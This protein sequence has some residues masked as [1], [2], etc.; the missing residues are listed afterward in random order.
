MEKYWAGKALAKARRAKKQSDFDESEFAPFIVAHTKKPETHVFCKITEKTIDRDTDAVSHDDE[1]KKFV[2]LLTH[3]ITSLHC[4]QVRRHI[5]GRRY[6]YLLKQLEEKRV[7][8][9]KKAEKRA[10]MLAKR[11]K[12]A[13]EHDD[14]ESFQEE[15]GDDDEEDDDDDEKDDEEND[16]VNGMN[17]AGTCWRP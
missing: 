6:K 9:A 17:V 10:A 12:D 8:Q 13:A 1:R 7:R 14:D 3:V 5:S 15:D 2:V 4:H 11:G 16:H